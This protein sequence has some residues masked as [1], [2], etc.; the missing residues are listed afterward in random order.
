MASPISR[1]SLLVLLTCALS[2][3]A[4]TAALRSGERAELD[5][6][7]DQAVMEYTRALQA[8]PSNASAQ[9]GLER[10]RLRSAQNHFSRGRQLYADGMLNDAVIE[11]QLAEELNPTDSNV[12]ELLTTVEAQLR[13]RTVV[14]SAGKT[15][16]ETLIERSQTFQPLGFSL[17][18][19]V[20]LPASLTFRDASSRDVYTV[21]A[22]MADVNIVFDPQ[23]RARRQTRPR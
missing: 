1:I 11:L 5:R 17:P 19:N 8:D 4:T 21:L 16:L 18:A 10:S 22:R 20:R 13:T 7:Y 2:G 15:D 12:Q 9:Q 14:A 23:F 6:D 3:C